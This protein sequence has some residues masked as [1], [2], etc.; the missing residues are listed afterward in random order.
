MAEEAGA[1]PATP[2][3]TARLANVSGYLTIRVSSMAEAAG[4]APAT[5][6]LAARFPGVCGQ[7]TIRVASRNFGGDGVT[8]TRAPFQGP[9]L[10]RRGGTL[11][12]FVSMV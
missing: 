6:F 5:L 7:L 10:S 2:S 12:A 9:P 1:A 3:R 4:A 8:C 11:A